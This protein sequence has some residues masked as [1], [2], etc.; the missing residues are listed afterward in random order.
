MNKHNN[1]TQGKG[2]LDTKKYCVWSTS[3]DR[4]LY[5]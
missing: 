4:N 5:L 3:I 1:V 2:E